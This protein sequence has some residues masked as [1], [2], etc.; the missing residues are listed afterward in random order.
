[1]VELKGIKQGAHMIFVV[2]NIALERSSSPPTAS[3]HSNV[4]FSCIME[5][6]R[7]DALEAAVP[8]DSSPHHRY[9]SWSRINK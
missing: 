2:G 9:K 7:I 6:G 1:M 5:D 4:P 8:T 3:Y